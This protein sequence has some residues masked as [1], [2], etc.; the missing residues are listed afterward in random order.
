MASTTPPVVPTDSRKIVIKGL[1]KAQIAEQIDQ[2]GIRDSHLE[3]PTIS[4]I[5]HEEEPLSELWSRI[6][7]CL[8]IILLS[9]DSTD[10]KQ[11]LDFV[12][13]IF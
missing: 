1:E 6:E 7:S 8:A 13:L 10:T 2:A 3:T 11:I 5:M 12:S 4:M 9:K